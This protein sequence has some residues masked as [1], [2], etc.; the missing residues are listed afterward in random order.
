MKQFLF[1]FAMVFV[2]I[3]GFAQTQKIIIG[4][5]ACTEKNVQGLPALYYDHT[6]DSYGRSKSARM[7][8]LINIEKLEQNSRKNFQATG[9]VLHV[10]TRPGHSAYN[11]DG[12]LRQ[13]SSFTMYANPYYCSQQNLIAEATTAS[14]IAVMVNPAISGIYNKT[15]DF[16]VTD[17]SVRYDI[18]IQMIRSTNGPTF[19][20]AK[21]AN[22]SNYISEKS[23]LTGFADENENNHASFLKLINGEGYVEKHGSYDPTTSYGYRSVQR[24]FNITKPGVPV[25]VPVSRKEFLEA[26]LEYYEIEKT[27]FANEVADKAKNNNYKDRIS[28]LEADKAAYNQIYITKKARISNLLATKTADWL[29]KQAAPNDKMREND[30]KIASNGLFDFYDFENGT[31]LY[32]YNP[33][34]SKTKD[35]YKP[36]MISVRCTYRYGN[37]S[38]RWSEDLF[39]NFVQNFDF[40][41]LRKM[42]P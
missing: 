29:G 4:K 10:Y 35:P 23:M 27:N 20:T 37:E 17:K 1:F 28:V 3:T 32:K 14:E 21:Y 36:V 8:Y 30:N 26:L 24:F 38:Y 34:F 40:E 15:G 33:E 13:Y 16:Y 11:M 12:V 42:L 6:F 41:A 39:K 31:P 5:T 9:C 25:L 22:I 7:P 2:S 19:P 18:S